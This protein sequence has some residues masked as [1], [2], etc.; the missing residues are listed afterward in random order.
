MRIVIWCVQLT[1]GGGEVGAGEGGVIKIWYRES[2]LEGGNEQIFGWR[3]LGAP[4][5]FLFLCSLSH[6]FS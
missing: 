3:G 1:F 6:W 4:V 2:L 5:C